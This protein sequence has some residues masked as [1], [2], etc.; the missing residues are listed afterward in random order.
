VPG[1]SSVRRSLHEAADTAAVVDAAIDALHAQYGPVRLAPLTIVIAAYNEQDGI[2]AVVD[3]I[4]THIAGLDVSIVVVDDGSTDK[5]SHVVE[6][7][8][9]LVC[10][11]AVNCGHGSALR[12]GYRIAREGGATYIATLDADGQ[13]NP[14]DLPAMVELMESDQADMVLGSRQLGATDNDDTV[15]NVG[16]K[17]FSR[18][19]SL[20]T[21]SSV[22]DSS[23]GLRAMR[24]EITATVRQTQPQYQTSELLIGALMAGYRV[25]EV[26]TTMRIRNA[27]ESKKGR[28]LLYG[29]RY[30]E[31]VRR[32]WWRERRSA[33]AVVV[34]GGSGRNRG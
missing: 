4:P 10:R 2:G 3:E 12:A 8:G 21:A 13:W 28:N 17:F 24:A 15:R 31:V 1:S 16:V 34:R 18:V 22:T 32:T 26:P 6:E 7:R 14:A 9:V 11:L 29:L 23:S 30:A 33:A 25:R 19:I 20:L 27:G 5:T